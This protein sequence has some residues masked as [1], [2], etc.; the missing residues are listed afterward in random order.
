MTFRKRHKIEMN[1]NISY[2]THDYQDN[3]YEIYNLKTS[4]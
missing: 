4:G 2:I 3:I 1:R